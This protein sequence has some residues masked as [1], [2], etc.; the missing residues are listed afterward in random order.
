MSDLR[1]ALERQHA[2]MREAKRPHTAYERQ[3]EQDRQA[4]AARL[5]Q[6][7]EYNAK[8]QRRLR[9]LLGDQ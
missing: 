6:M 9:D 2:A 3:Q 8:R 7:E 4:H 1:T 5:R